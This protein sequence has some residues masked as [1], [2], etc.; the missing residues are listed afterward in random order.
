MMNRPAAILDVLKEDIY[1]E[2]LPFG[3]DACCAGTSKK[4][5]QFFQQWEDHERDAFCSYQWEI[6]APYFTLACTPADDVPHYDFA[7]EVVLPFIQPSVE[8]PANDNDTSHQLVIRSNNSTVWMVKIHQEHHN[9]Y[10]KQVSCSP[11]L[12][13]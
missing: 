3:S 9:Y 4:S 5:I 6:N 1:D 12:A 13:V 11:C 10:E 2:D 8:K 7:S